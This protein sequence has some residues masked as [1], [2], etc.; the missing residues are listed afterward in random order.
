[1]MTSF[2]SAYE[3]QTAPLEGHRRAR[4]HS[5]GAGATPH[6]TQRRWQED[7]RGASRQPAGEN[8]GGGSGGGSGDEGGQEETPWRTR[9]R[10]VAHAPPGGSTHA[11]RRMLLG[12]RRAGTEMARESEDL[13][14]QEEG[15]YH[16]E[17]RV[18][19]AMRAYKSVLT[20]RPHTH[21][22]Q[23]ATRNFGAEFLLPIGRRQTQ[24]EADYP[25]V[26]TVPAPH[27]PPST[28]AKYPAPQSETPSDQPEH[29]H[30]QEDQDA[31]PRTPIDLGD[32]EDAPMIDLDDGMEDRDLVDSGEEASGSMEE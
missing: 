19:R 26:R 1:M 23:L 6:T 27:V 20:S 32:G 18:V 11:T 22:L 12:E 17:V 4:A 8:D 16:Q 15:V 21:A 2:T 29:E 7:V 31:E 25:A 3:H 10:G 13:S 9:E 14:D 28:P 5:S 24:V 30:R